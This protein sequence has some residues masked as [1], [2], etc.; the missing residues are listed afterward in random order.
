MYF[1]CKTS[2]RII[3]MTNVKQALY[4]YCW[5]YV[6]QRRARLQEEIHLIQASANEETK[7]SAGDKYETG[8]SMAQLEIERNSQQLNEANKLQQVLKGITPDHVSDVVIPG[9][10]VHT[11]H[12][13]FYIAISIGVFTLE[14]KQFLIISSDSPIG[15]LLMGRKVGDTITWNKMTYTIQIIE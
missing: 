10:V 12:G 4:D 11:S 14:E 9:S 13:V 2:L 6:E 15:K 3:C 5:Q 8:R 7:S 1:S